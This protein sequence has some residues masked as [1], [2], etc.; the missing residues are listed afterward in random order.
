MRNQLH[1][2]YW[3]IHLFDP[4]WLQPV[5]ALLFSEQMHFQLL[6]GQNVL[7]FYQDQQPQN[8]ME[9][10][11]KSF[12]LGSMRRKLMP[13]PGVLIINV[14][15][16][17]I[18]NKI[19]LISCL[20]RCTLISTLEGLDVGVLAFLRNP[21]GVDFYCMMYF[22]D[23]WTDRDWTLPTLVCLAYLANKFPLSFQLILQETDCQ[24]LW[25]W[26]PL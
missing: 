6:E 8:P 3:S 18:G 24:T 22:F 25:H 10:E 26:T 21:A 9:R 15:I 7:F 14:S 19:R 11:R 1:A 12:W 13:K 5:M 4:Y 16:I 20:W 23:H 2:S 17:N